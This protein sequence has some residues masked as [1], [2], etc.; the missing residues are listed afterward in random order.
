M[1]LH[2]SVTR[3][4]EKSSCKTL[5]IEP[6]SHTCSKNYVVGVGWRRDMMRTWRKRRHKKQEREKKRRKRG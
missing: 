6:D 4:R 3:I 5:D 1:F 2:Q